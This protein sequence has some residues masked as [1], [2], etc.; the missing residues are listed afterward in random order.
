MIDVSRA[1][2]NGRA[3][4]SFRA[5]AVLRGAILAALAVSAAMP[6]QADSDELQ[7][8][9]QQ[10]QE[11][12][13]RLDALT[14][15]QAAKPAT[16]AAPVP[17]PAE[18]AKPAPTTATFYAG[19]VAVTLGGFV[20]LMVVNRSRNEASDWAS[21]FNAAVP[22]PQSPNYQLSE[23]H[24]TE[25]QSRWQALAQGP[26]D[27]NVVVEGYIEG[28]FGSAPTNGNNNE[29]TT[30]APRVRHFFADYLR[31]D[32]GWYL[33]FGQTWSLLTQNREGIQLRR[34]N[35][36][37]T[38]DGQYIPGYNWTRVPQ[39]R[40]VKT[41]G[42]SVAFGLSAENPAMLLTATTT[43]TPAYQASINY[44]PFFATQGA[45]GAYAGLITTDSLPD[46][47]AKF[48]FDPGWGHYEIFGMSRSFRDRNANLAGAPH[49][50]NTTTATS[51]GGSVL[52]PLVP[53]VLEF[54]ASVLA[55][56][57]VGRY[58]SA[59][60]ADATLKPD[61]SIAAIKGYSYLGGLIWRPDPVWTLFA[62]WGAEHVDKTDFTAVVNATTRYGF[63][64]GSPLFSN[65]NCGIEGST[66][67]C[68]ANTSSIV[69]G[70]IG[71]WW[72]FYRGPIGYM[73]VGATLT[74]LK[75]EIYADSAGNNPS[76]NLNIGLI[77]FRY[78]PYQK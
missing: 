19:P 69:S 49:G 27:P 77:S 4:R 11:L 43:A 70:T 41:F 51:G 33:E 28:D 67:S 72:R 14:Q 1:S 31:K 38:I 60:L 48:A 59:Q 8:L 68:A 10:V 62:Y 3:A 12:T 9:R 36:P 64:Y 5:P 22:F 58:G 54:T 29:S 76:S 55:G 34:E 47:L 24:L 66:G 18:P 20:E 74:N 44:A 42:S 78:Y 6:A 37:V 26:A 46:F 56:E 52:L 32:A 21:S 71:A 75:R 73:Q 50:N 57:G 15:Q 30:F 25:R 16:A 53:R 7:A 23:F 61:G 13:R 35:I 39:V 17:V 63:G 2:N 45:P 65:K 40:F